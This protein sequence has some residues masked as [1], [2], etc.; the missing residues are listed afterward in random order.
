MAQ[1]IGWLFAVALVVAVLRVIWPFIVLG[2][3]VY[4]AVK[5]A[6]GVADHYAQLIAARR[7]DRD[8]LCARADRQ[9]AQV[10]RGNPAGVY[11]DY[12]AADLGEFNPV[13]WVCNQPP[14]RRSYQ[15][16]SVNG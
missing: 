16:T 11:G 5:I 1:L 13:L 8:A 7:A 4:L 6:R 3:A 15:R 10:L 14:A 2:I 9:H 12:P